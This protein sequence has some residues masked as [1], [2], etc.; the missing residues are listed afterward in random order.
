VTVARPLVH[1]LLC[2]FACGCAVG[3]PAPEVTKM[4]EVKTGLTFQL[5]LG[6]QGCGIPQSESACKAVAT[7]DA[8]Q[9]ALQVQLKP[10]ALDVHEVTVEQYEYCVAMEICSEPVGTN[11]PGGI[12]DYY[13]QAK[14][15]Q[16]PVVLV[17]Q[18][19]AAEYCKSV[20]KRLPTEFEWER[21]AGGPATK[22]AEKR[23]FPFA[24][25]GPDAKLV[26]GQ[27]SKNV[28]AWPC[29]GG[30]AVTTAVKSQ[31][32]DAVSE[33][34]TKV[35]DLMGNVS[36]WTASDANTK[37]TCDLS[38][39]YD[40]EECVKC[41]QK[42]GISSLNC[43]PK[44]SECKC[45]EGSAPLK[46][47]NCYSPC[48]TPICPLYKAGTVLDGSFTGKNALDKR[49]IRG[50]NFQTPDASRQ[51]CAN[52]SDNRTFALPPNGPPQVFL[53]FR[54]AKDL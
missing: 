20:G 30:S 48:T 14:Y 16:H 19:Q 9:P 31:A 1:A 37:A 41:L 53:G 5:G 4:A 42:E 24:E 13:P 26:A 21:V 36:E 54:C 47:P 45:G 51:P 44:C 46:K 12:P 49:M 27:C 23:L 50:G 18:I 6:E 10:F 17:S 29:N 52:R 3:R 25:P 38:Q 43:K 33:G 40:C 39:P 11:G 7:F 2:V 8:G 15:L 28:N 22:A 35:F 34:G 32:D